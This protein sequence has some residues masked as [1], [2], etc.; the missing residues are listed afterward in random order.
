MNALIKVNNISITKGQ[1]KIL[2]KVSL[3]LAAQD[4]ITIIGPNGAGKS[5][6]LKVLLGLTRA[7]EGSVET[8]P[9]LKIGYMPQQLAVQPTL[10]LKV[11]DFLLLKQNI[12]KAALDRVV[13]E[14]NIES[15]LHKMLYTLS[16]GELQN[17]LLARALLGE[18][19]LLVLDEPAQN[20][21][22]AGQL[23]LYQ[24]LDRVYA[25]RA[26]SILMVS[27][28]L[29]FVMSSTKQVVCLFHHICCSGAPQHITKEPE[30]ISLFGVAAQ[31]LLA[32][33]SHKHDHKH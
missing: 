8:K 29:H 11:L 22:I 2:D 17:V 3:T 5:M 26:V 12:T 10:P 32:A 4:F 15:S 1:E 20:L 18:P 16:S 13:A 21:D 14:T 27:H 19:E 31:N 30:F 6:L 24:L 25:K 7:D 28:D 33:Y 23:A 9:N